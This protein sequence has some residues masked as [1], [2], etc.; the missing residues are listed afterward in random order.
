MTET[1]MISMDE[2]KALIDENGDYVLID[3]REKDELS[4]GMIP[5]A[6]HIPLQEVPWALSTTP[7][8]FEKK[9]QFPQPKKTDLVIFHC[10]TG[11][12]SDAA[13]QQA[14]TAGYT[15]AKNFAGSIWEWAE[16]DQNVKRY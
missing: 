16:I 9:F 10:R 7:E 3:V 11:G 2:L 8:V 5:T 6:H 12:R 13:T 15:N 14:V 1:P 4:Y